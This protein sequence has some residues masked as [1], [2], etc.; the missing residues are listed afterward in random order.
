MSKQSTCR[1]ANSLSHRNLVATGS[2]LLSMILTHPGA[3]STHQQ[4]RNILS[5]LGIVTL[6]AVVGRFVRFSGVLSK[7]PLIRRFFRNITSKLPYLRQAK[8]AQ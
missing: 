1:L 3:S 6:R 8:I 4:A 7:F 5:E 2:G